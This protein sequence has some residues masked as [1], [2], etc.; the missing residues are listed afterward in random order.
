ML[1]NLKTKLR[2]ADRT[3][4]KEPVLD[5]NNKPTGE[6][7]DARVKNLMIIAIQRGYNEQKGDKEEQKSKDFQIQM[8]LVMAEDTVD[9]EIDEAARLKTMVT[10]WYDSFL[11]GQL[12]YI[13][14]N[15]EIPF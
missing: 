6:L 8:K 4:M 3:D 9:L 2:S 14:E 11:G 13:I 7:Q 10:R 15:K 1:I 5:E 12:N